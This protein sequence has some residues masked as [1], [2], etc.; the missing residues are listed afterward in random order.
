MPPYFSFTR[1]AHEQTRQWR[2]KLTLVRLQTWS[3]TALGVGMKILCIK[4]HV[5]SIFVKELERL[6]APVSWYRPFEL[7]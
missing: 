6:I 4:D 2:L 3:L 5:R 7:I 1:S